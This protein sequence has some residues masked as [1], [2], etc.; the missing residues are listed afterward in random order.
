MNL[1]ISFRGM[2]YISLVRLR[3]CLSSLEG[4]TSLLV[5]LAS[6]TSFSG[7][8][9]WPAQAQ[10]AASIV[11]RWLQER[12]VAS[13]TIQK[14]ADEEVTTPEDL[15]ALGLKM[16]PRKSAAQA[17]PIEWHGNLTYA[18]PYGVNGHVCFILAPRYG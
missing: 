14:L 2:N 4:G 8:P 3:R 16:G 9:S 12:G 1:L 13:E 15:L 7:W 17:V 5:R 10:L 11:S 18:G 6:R